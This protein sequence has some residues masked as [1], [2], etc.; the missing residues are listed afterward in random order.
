MEKA[1][2]EGSASVTGL[3]LRHRELEQRLAALERH[4]SLT[5]AEQ[6]ERSRLKKE[7]LW[8]KDRLLALTASAQTAERLR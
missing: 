5:P 3:Q 6:I 7:K 1:S 4:L 2:F 8:I